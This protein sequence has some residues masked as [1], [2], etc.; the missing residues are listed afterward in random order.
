[1][2]EQVKSSE[3]KII[4]LK[5]LVQGKERVVSE[6]LKTKLRA[7]HAKEYMPTET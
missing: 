1:M 4:R 3:A 2:E 6:E 5:K 7:Y